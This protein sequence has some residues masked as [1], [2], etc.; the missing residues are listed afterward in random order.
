MEKRLIKM[1]ILD[2]TPYEGNPRKNKKAVKAVAESIEQ[3]GY[4]NP[5]IVDEDGVILA[6]HTRRLSLIENGETG[7]V[8]VL[9][10]TG[11]S[12][13]NKRK[14]R[15]LDNKTAEYSAWDFVAL[16]EELSILDFGE[17]QLDW[18]VGDNWD[19]DEEAEEQGEK[20]KSKGKEYVCQECG[21]HFTA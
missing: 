10:I 5:I 17:L 3:T 16:S 21:F 1:N 11:L 20:K 14:F 18:G 8:D 4:N 6:G 13:E 7:E 19:A 12:K 9:Q 15:L 2:I